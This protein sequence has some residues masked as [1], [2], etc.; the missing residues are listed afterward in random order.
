MIVDLRLQ[1]LSTCTFNVMPVA[2]LTRPGSS[3]INLIDNLSISSLHFEVLPRQLCQA[4]GPVVVAV[5][6]NVETMFF[7]SVIQL[8]ANGICSSNEG[9]NLKASCKW[10][11]IPFYASDAK[12]AELVIMSVEDQFV[13]LNEPQP[14]A[15]R[16]NWDCSDGSI[17]SEDDFLLLGEVDVSCERFSFPADSFFSAL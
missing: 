4:L 17:E 9:H 7:S 16:G 1:H 8:S 14:V 3:A 10:L 11:S 2:L 13:A 6:G 12:E 5:E 15:P